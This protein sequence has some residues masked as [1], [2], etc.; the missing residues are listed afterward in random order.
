MQWIAGRSRLFGNVRRYSGKNSLHGSY[1]FLAASWGLRE[2][3]HQPAK[4]A[5]ELGAQA[6]MVALLVNFLSDDL[7]GL[8]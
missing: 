6:G 1:I 7:A 5:L 2:R 3:S 8:V 4:R